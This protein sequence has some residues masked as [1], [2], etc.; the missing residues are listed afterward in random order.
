MWQ[1]GLKRLRPTGTDKWPNNSG[2]RRFLM[3]CFVVGRCAVTKNILI[4]DGKVEANNTNKQTIQQFI[5]DNKWRNIGHA[6]M[7]LTF[8]MVL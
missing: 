5:D 8:K 7:S 6:I 1:R 2:T 4:N 3:R